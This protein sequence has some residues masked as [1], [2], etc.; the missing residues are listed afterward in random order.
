MPGHR[1][2]KLRLVRHFNHI[3]VVQPDVARQR[4][5][6]RQVHNEFSRLRPKGRRLN[7]KAQVFGVPWQSAATTPLRVKWIS[8]VGNGR[9]HP[10]TVANVLK[11][12]HTNS[13]GREPT[14]IRH[15]HIRPLRGRIFRCC[16][17]V[18]LHPRLFILDHFAACKSQDSATVRAATV[19]CNRQAG[20]LRKPLLTAVKT[21]N[22]TQL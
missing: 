16:R 13:R 19:R 10:D 2:P 6:L 4:R 14:V 5:I 3:P 22:T 17:S 1:T 7:A 9:A 20:E 21:R 11:G 15:K 12:R 18:G 8:G